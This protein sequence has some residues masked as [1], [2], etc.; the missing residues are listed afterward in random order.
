MAMKKETAKELNDLAS[1]IL[2]D[3]GSKY[4]KLVNGEVYIYIIKKMVYLFLCLAMFLNAK[5]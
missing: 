2:L 3:N 4:L 1:E 5:C